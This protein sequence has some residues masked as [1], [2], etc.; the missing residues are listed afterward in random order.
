MTPYEDHYRTLL[1]RHYTWMA[2]VPFADK[3]AEQTRVL[4]EM[5][6]ADPGMAIDLGCGP[7]FQSV[8]LADMGARHVHA[9]D[10][11]EALLSEL[12]QHTEGRPITPHIGDL[13]RFD[14]L[15][16]ETADTIVCMGDTITHLPCQ[17]DVA[18]VFERVAS[19]LRPG[20]RFCL[21]WR[22]LSRPP[23]GLDRFIPVRSD[24]TRAML[25]FLEDQGETV[26]VHDL[27]HARANEEWT[28][29]KSAY[30]KL[31][32]SPAWVRDALRAAGLTPAAEHTV[33]GMTHVVAE[34]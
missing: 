6:V 23:C 12:M 20:G 30:P 5:G 9:V 29:H 24:E 13:R 25:C 26:L 3:V 14:V 15:V 4:R 11:S 2:G 10:T 31:K 18:R 8:A 7:G 34:K 17:D 22:D 27:I 28:L 19:S 32:L 21:S 16:K 33:R 1:A